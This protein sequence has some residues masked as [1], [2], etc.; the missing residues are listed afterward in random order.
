ML[1]FAASTS[2][3]ARQKL[4]TPVDTAML[5]SRMPTGTRQ[6]DLIVLGAGAAGL[7]CSAIASQRGRRVAL[8]DHN[9]QPGRKILISGGGRCNFTNMHC[10][11]ANFQSR[12]PHFAKSALALYQPHHFIELVDRYGIAWHEKTLGQLFCD[13]TAHSILDMLLA[14]CRCGPG[15]VE[16]LLDTRVLK[17]EGTA[18]GGFRVETSRSEIAAEALVVATGSQAWRQ[19][20]GLRSGPPVRPEGG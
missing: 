6:F 7:M 11:P 5:E 13:G 17:V 9:A 3:S 18:S 15:A 2:Q 4:S 16:F 14:E 12:N 10:T 19:R 8:V 20:I 1:K